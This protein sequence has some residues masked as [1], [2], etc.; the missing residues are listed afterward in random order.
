ME[1]RKRREEN[2]SLFVAID[3][4]TVPVKNLEKKAHEKEVKDMA[5][6]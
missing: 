2:V 1:R 4:Y 6:L 5:L 3:E